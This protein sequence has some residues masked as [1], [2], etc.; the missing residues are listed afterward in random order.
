M[1]V[2]ILYYVL[3]IGGEVD[4]VVGDREWGGDGGQGVT[5]FVH[6]PEI[7]VR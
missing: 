1:W 5:G 7:P 4:Y 3:V 6:L 2:V